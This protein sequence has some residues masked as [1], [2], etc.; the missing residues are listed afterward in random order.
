MSHGKPDEPTPLAHEPRQTLQQLLSTPE[1]SD[2]P[3]LV[4]ANKQDAAGAFSA[5][6]VPE[7]HRQRYP[8]LTYSS[9]S[10]SPEPNPGA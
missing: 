9:P 5:H 7:A 4:M 8:T 10:P 2:I 1:L 6:E 3:L